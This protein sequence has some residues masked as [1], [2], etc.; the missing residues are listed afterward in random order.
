M[1]VKGQLHILA[2]LLLG[3]DAPSSHWKGCWVVD[4]TGLDD[5]DERKVYP[6]EN[7]TMIL[8]LFSL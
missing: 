6:A 4:I 7:W 3:K 5:L 2:T 1:K 8:Q